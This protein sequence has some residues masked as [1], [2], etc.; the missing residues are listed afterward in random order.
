[1]S[2][3]DNLV[4]IHELSF[5]RGSR[6]I[7]DKINLKIARGKI[8]AIM[9]PSGVGKTTILKLISAQ[10]RPDSGTVTVNGQNIHTLSS[11]KLYQ[12]RRNIGM[13]FQSS[14]LFTHMNVFENVAFALREHTKLPEEMIRDLVLMRLESVGLRGA[15]KMMPS[16]LSGGMSRRVA[17][18]RSLIMDPQLMLYDEP[19]S[20]QDPITM[21]LLTKLI[22]ELNEALQLTSV[23]VSH[24]VA[25]TASIADYIY[26]ISK[27]EVISHG[28]SKEVY[29][30]SD[31]KTQQF[32]HGKPDGPVP[33][34]YPAK[35][36]KED[37]DL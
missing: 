19:F 27:G 2:N 20:G 32:I 25:E 26:I 37:L 11:R 31:P 16:E 36:L 4:E 10:W 23:V 18:A 30:D 1:M 35:D 12:A 13:L 22:K 33:F 8:T 7:F 29:D 14:G 9:G 3:K 34:H 21:G 17:L 28:T 24:D 5:S 6:T 15:S